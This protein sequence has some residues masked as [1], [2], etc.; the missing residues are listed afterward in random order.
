MI[1]K[2]S[3]PTPLNDNRIHG[4]SWLV[5]TTIGEYINMISVEGNPYQRSILGLKYYSKLID[6]LLL[7]TVIPPISVV[8]N[9]SNLAITQGVNL[10]GKLFI[11][12]GLQRTNCIKHCINLLEKKDRTKFI[13][14][15]K[16]VD[17]FLNK[18]IYLE[19]WEKIEFKNILYKMIVLNTGQ[20]KMD[21]SHQLDILNNAFL[22][23]ITEDGVEVITRIEQ[24]E[25][26][27]KKNEK[28]LLADLTEALVSY[29]NCFPISGKKNAAEFLFERFNIGYSSQEENEGLEIIFNDNTYENIKW[30]LTVFSKKLDNIYG[31]NNPI[32]KYNVF[33]IGLA[34]SM[35]FAFKKNPE[36]YNKKVK[37]LENISGDDPLKIS[38]YEEYNSKFKSGIGEKRR[39]YVYEEFRNFFIGPEYIEELEWDNTYER[40]FN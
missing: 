7:D 33:L 16:S 34:A 39:K 19:I 5:V 30:I 26:K 23:K 12:D 2:N 28:F 18:E 31:N 37:I 36:N 17:E 35:G 20:K 13:T 14:S 15:F 9:K 27:I 11:L 10:E 6:D 21:Y 1:I 22:E 8:I 25:S 38:L 40:Y 4:K 29:I 24:Q 32:K 3:I